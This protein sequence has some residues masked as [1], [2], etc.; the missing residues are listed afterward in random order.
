MMSGCRRRS[1]DGSDRPTTSR[2]CG[3]GT[4][5]MHILEDRYPVCD[6]AARIERLSEIKNGSALEMKRLDRDGSGPEIAHET[7]L[8]VFDLKP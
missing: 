7:K 3:D 2:H 8:T 1:R 4:S 5:P 6:G